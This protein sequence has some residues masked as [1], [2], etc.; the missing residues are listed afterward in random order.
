MILFS[1]AAVI[2]IFFDLL[3]KHLISSGMEL[4]SSITLSPGFLDFTY[5]INE[6]AAWGFLANRQWLL[7][8]FT[9][10]VMLVLIIYAV[11]KRNIIS[12]LQM[13]SLAMI[14]GGGLGNFISR[15]FE[16]HVVD[17]IHIRALSFFN[18]FNIADIGITV[19]CVILIFC[20]VFSERSRNA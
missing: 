2:V 7:Q 16:G 18:I 5:I 15:L 12:R 8:V 3:T 17:F 19:G 20:T 6:G 9:G 1:A 10:A 13:V 4:N 14:V 11:R